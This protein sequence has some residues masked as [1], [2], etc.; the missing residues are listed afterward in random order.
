MRKILISLIVVLLFNTTIT[1]QSFTCGDTIY[2][3]DGN[4]YPTVLIGTQCWMAKNLNVGVKVNSA[5]T[6]NG[7]IEKICFDDNAANCVTY[8]GM[9]QWDEMMQYS[10]TEGIQGICPDNTH[11]PTHSEYTTLIDYL[12]GSSVAGG[13][14][15]EAGTSHWESPNTGATNSSG[16]TALPGGIWD[17]GNDTFWD[18]GYNTFFRTST[19]TDATYPGYSWS[20]YLQRYSASAS[21]DNINNPYGYYVRCICDEATSVENLNKQQ[22]FIIFPN[23][24]TGVFTVEGKDINKIE[25]IDITGKQVSLKT[26]FNINSLI[27]D[28]NN[29]VKG[30]YFVKIHTNSI[31]DVRKIIIE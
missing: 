20:V 6:N 11:I 15:K 3:F 17:Y 21:F 1:A 25:V 18:L 13:E 29:Q 19:L 12:G 26:D 5:Q 10:T 30:I 8:G 4:A 7:V 28:L 22:D 9:Y 24:T 16:F 2:D 23:P 14:M 27:I 31:I